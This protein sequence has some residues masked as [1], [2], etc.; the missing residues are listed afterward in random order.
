[1]ALSGS[2]EDYLTELL[3]RVEVSS[4]PAKSGTLFG[5]EHHDVVEG[6]KEKWW[7]WLE[8]EKRFRKCLAMRYYNFHFYS[9]NV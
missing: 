4:D 2:N 9:Y 6:F 7:K 5:S 3:D 1:M 8:T